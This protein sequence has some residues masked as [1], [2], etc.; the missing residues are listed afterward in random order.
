MRSSLADAY[1]VRAPETQEVSVVARARA[2]AQ[3]ISTHSG[4]GFIDGFFRLELDCAALYGGPLDAL[5]AE[6]M[7]EVEGLGWANRSARSLHLNL[8]A[9]ER[10]EPIDAGAGREVAASRGR[11]RLASSL[12]A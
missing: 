8:S 11:P 7:R 2:E 12:P 5:V 9:P 1:A 4:T 3:A 10:T 6:W